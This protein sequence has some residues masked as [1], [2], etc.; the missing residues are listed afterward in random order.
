M[1]FPPLP[2]AH[3]AKRS[4]EVVEVEVKRNGIALRG[5]HVNGGGAGG[6]VFDGEIELES[7]AGEGAAAVLRTDEIGLAGR[8]KGFELLVFAGNL[9]VEIFPEVVRTRGK[10]GRTGARTCG[11]SY[12]WAI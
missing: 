7:G 3:G 5:K 9:N 2:V 4:A 11:A 10:G 8:R 1:S 12:K 6:K